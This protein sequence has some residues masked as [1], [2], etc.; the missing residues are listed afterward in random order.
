MKKTTPASATPAE[1]PTGEQVCFV[2]CA[3]GEEG[4]ET[5]IRADQVMKHFIEPASEEC[6]YGK[7]VRADTEG[8]PGEITARIIM[9]LIDDPIVVA[10]LTGRNPNVYYELAV[11]H[12]F[13]R[14]VV[15]IIERGEELPFDVGGQGAIHVDTTDLDSPAKCVPELVAHIHAAVSAG[16]GMT[17]PVSLATAMEAMLASGEP[18]AAFN[19]AI[20]EKLEAMASDLRHLRQADVD[21]GAPASRWGPYSVDLVTDPVASS[22]STVSI[23]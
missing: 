18:A 13:R 3:I 9:H 20:M 5:R 15:S 4:T 23:R 19:Q 8:K 12:C 10:D 16:E 22:C 6:G 2:I 17:T 1:Q 11:R 21:R 14:P 7:P